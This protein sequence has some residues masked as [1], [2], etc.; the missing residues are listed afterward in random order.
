MIVYLINKETNEIINE[1]K[2]VISWG[3]NFVEFNNGGRCKI[4]CNS[5]TEYF[6]DEKLEEIEDEQ[7]TEEI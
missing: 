4:Y 5:E 2:N 6:T 7:P 1:Y 3:Y